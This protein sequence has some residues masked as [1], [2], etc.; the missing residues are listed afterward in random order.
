[1][2]WLLCSMY[3]FIYLIYIFI[4]TCSAFAFFFIAFTIPHT[5]NIQ[6]ILKLKC[7]FDAFVY[8]V[9]TVHVKF[10]VKWLILFCHGIVDPFGFDISTTT[11]NT[12]QHRT[13]RTLANTRN[14]WKNWFFV[15][16]LP[17]SWIRILEYYRYYMT[18]STMFHCVRVC[19][20]STG[21]DACASCSPWLVLKC[22]QSRF[23]EL[24]CSRIFLNW[25]HSQAIW[26]AVAEKNC[27]FQVVRLQRERH[28][29][30]LWICN[31]MIACYSYSCT[32]SLVCL[33]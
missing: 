6:N 14:R 26:M 20:E 3:L 21:D 1:M 27:I 22:A 33:G 7:F 10:I 25:P 28:H 12:T 17:H 19:M 31:K 4:I 5:K 24:N 18:N 23:R 29:A 32:S 8:S 9:F 16:W 11:Q 15:E 2:Y 30:N 13:H